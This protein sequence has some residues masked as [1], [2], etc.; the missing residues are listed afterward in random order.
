MEGMKITLEQVESLR[1][2]VECD[3]QTAERALRKNGGDEDQAVLYILKGREKKWRQGVE[4]LKELIVKVLGFQL[5]LLRN[6]KPLIRFPILLIGAVVVLLD[7]PMILLLIL[8]VASVVLGYEYEVCYRE[9]EEEE[10]LEKTSSPEEDEAQ[11]AEREPAPEEAREG[12][13]MDPEGTQQADYE[14]IIIE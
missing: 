10:H 13:Q 3:Y 11:E 6:Q 9:G 8:A 14:E 2:R 4:M 1:S 7:I 12:A 5:V